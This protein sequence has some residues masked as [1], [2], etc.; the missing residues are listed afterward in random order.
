[1]QS[2]KDDGCPLLNA[3]IRHDMFNMPVVAPSPASIQSG[4][5]I[6]NKHVVEYWKA[7]PH[8]LPNIIFADTYIYIYNIYYTR[9]FGD[10]SMNQ[11]I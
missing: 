2:T 10:S 6:N 4:N 11:S 1:M 8:V 7:K 9:V 3:V 5:H